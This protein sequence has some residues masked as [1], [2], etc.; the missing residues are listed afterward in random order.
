MVAREMTVPSPIHYA[1]YFDRHYLARGLALYR[2]LVRHSRPFV[3]WVLCLDEDTE[4]TLATMRPGNVVSLSLRELERADPALAA[5][6]A[7]RHLYEYYWTCGPA[8]LLYLL[9]LPYVRE[10]K[11]ARALIRAAGGTLPAVDSVHLGKERT[12]S[13]LDIARRRSFFVVIG[14]LVL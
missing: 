9:E 8:Y 7:D 3:L 12:R 4:R 6:R 13:L 10:P 5:A 14:P 1:T 2:S 11:A